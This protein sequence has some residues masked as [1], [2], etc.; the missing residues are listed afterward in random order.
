MTEFQIQ[1]SFVTEI[2]LYPAIRQY[3]FAVPNGG[4]R[5][6]LEAINLKAQGVTPGVP[7]LFLSIPTEKH[8]GLYLECK[9]MKGK[10]TEAQ[11]KKIFIFKAIGYECIIFRTPTEAVEA[12]KEYLGLTNLRD[13][14]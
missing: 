13:F 10:L 7:D 4:S 8:H 6:M 5:H 12:V 3:L 2:S 14:K 11:K 1:K 9:S